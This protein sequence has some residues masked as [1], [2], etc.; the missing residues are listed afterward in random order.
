MPF[1]G[2]AR[3]MHNLKNAAQLEIEKGK[4]LYLEE[5]RRRA[6]GFSFT[7]VTVPSHWCVRFLGTSERMSLRREVRPT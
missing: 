1:K 2:P 7:H 3:C 6:G 5:A 4:Q